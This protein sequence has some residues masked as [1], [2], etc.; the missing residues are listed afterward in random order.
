VGGKVGGLCSSA[1]S[2]AAGD[3]GAANRSAPSATGSGDRCAAAE[4]AVPVPVV[5]LT[6][7]VVLGR[8]A[9]AGC[10][11][12][13][14]GRRFLGLDAQHDMRLQRGA[15]TACLPAAPRHLAPPGAPPPGQCRPAVAATGR[16]PRTHGPAA[17]IFLSCAGLMIMD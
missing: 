7:A 3:W 17:A 9:A 16:T 8:G 15:S 6:V 5:A 2:P 4:L 13:G 10:C 11:G 12:S 14:C 1:A